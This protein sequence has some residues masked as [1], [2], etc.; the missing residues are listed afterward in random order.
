MKCTKRIFKRC[1]IAYE[2]IITDFSDNDNKITT[3][4]PLLNKEIYNQFNEA[5][6]KEVQEVIMLK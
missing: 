1:K 5:L 4:K 6:K 2:T 3:S